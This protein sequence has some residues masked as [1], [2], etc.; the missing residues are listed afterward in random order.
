MKARLWLLVLAVAC[1]ES[2]HRPAE[3]P[4][5][6]EPAPAPEEPSRIEILTREVHAAELRLMNAQQAIADAATDAERAAAREQ[7][8]EAKRQKAEADARLAQAR[9]EVEGGR[10]TGACANNPL[11]VGCP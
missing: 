7:L 2:K 3:P 11:A 4:Q 6:H 8:D 10:D 9:A 1:G 5:N